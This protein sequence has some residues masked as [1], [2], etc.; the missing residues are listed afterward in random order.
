MNRSTSKKK[1]PK[2]VLRLPDLDFAKRSVLNTLGSPQ[3]TRAY[4]FAIDDFVTWYCLEPRLAFSKAVVLRYRLELETRQLAPATINLRLAAVRRLAYGS[5]LLPIPCCSRQPESAQRL[6][7]SAGQVV[8][9]R[10]TSAQPA[11]SEAVG[12]VNSATGTLDSFPTSSASLPFGSLRRHAS[13]IRAVCV[14]APVRICAG[15]DQ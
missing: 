12:A 8:A 6:P 2:R 5:G 4:Q 1:I 9:S 14:N 11:R 7:A 3:S 10:V 13:K 15:G